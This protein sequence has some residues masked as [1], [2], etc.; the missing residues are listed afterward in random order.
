MPRGQT[1]PTVT[2]GWTRRSTSSSIVC[3]KP[4]GQDRFRDMLDALIAVSRQ[5]EPPVVLRSVI[6][7]AMG[8]VNARYGARGVP[9][10]DGQPLEECIPVGLNEHELADLAGVALWLNARVQCGGREGPPGLPGVGHCWSGPHRARGGEGQGGWGMGTAP[11]STRVSAGWVTGA[12]TRHAGRE[13]VRT[14]G[15]G[16]I[17]E[18]TCGGR[19]TVG[20]NVHSGGVG[21]PPGGRC[22]AGA[23]IATRRPRG[24]H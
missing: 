21:V 1:F 19:N 8:L 12:A 16:E 4:R 6:T 11:A 13:R 10:E 24:R 22:G 3:A 9:S 7:T 15:T 5:L 2:T 17:D 23:G 20:G 18:G 14:P